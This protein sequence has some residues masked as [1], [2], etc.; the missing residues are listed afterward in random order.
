[1]GSLQYGLN[2]T[3]GDGAAPVVGGQESGTEG[4][5]AASDA[6]RPHRAVALVRCAGGIVGGVVRSLAVNG[7][8]F[9]EQHWGETALELERLHRPG[10]A[11]HSYTRR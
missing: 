9:S 1:V 4:W 10:R 7:R 11:Y 8:S 2:V 3:A 6:D 5:L